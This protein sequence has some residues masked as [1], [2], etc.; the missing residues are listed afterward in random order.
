MAKKIF[1]LQNKLSLFFA[2]IAI[3]LVVIFIALV[4][5]FGLTNSEAK[6]VNAHIS[7]ELD[8]IHDKI[9]SDC[10]SVTLDGINLAAS[11]SASSNGFLESREISAAEFLR[12]PDLIEPY[13]ESQIYFLTA[14]INSRAC[15]GTFIILDTT[16]NPD[17]PDSKNSKAGLFLVKTQPLFTKMLGVWVHI[18]RGPA[19]IARK[20]GINLR[21]EWRLEYD[22]SENDTFDAIIESSRK[23]SHLPFSRLYYWTHRL[24]LK[25]YPESEFLL[26]VPIITKDGTVLG[27]CGIAISDIMFKQL[28][29]PTTEEFTG[30]FSVTAPIK[31]NKFL[32][33][34]GFMAGNYYVSGHFL[35]EN[36]D[37]AEKSEA[38]DFTKFNGVSG[39]YGGKYLPLRLYSEGSP[40]ENEKWAVAVMLPEK[41][42]DAAIS[43]NSKNFYLALAIILIVAIA[44]SVML[45]RYYMK[46]VH[47]AFDSIKHN[48]FDEDSGYLEISDLFEFLAEKD[49]EHEKELVD[50][51]KK[52]EDAKANFEDAQS[53]LEK[54]VDRQKYEVDAESYQ[55]FMENIG[56]LT[57]KERQIFDMYIS[58]FSAKDIVETSGITENTLKFHNKN[59]YGKL[60]IS[61]R[62]EMLMFAEIMNAK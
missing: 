2:S 13:L 59:I 24:V 16:A 23:N 33:S 35:G 45:S 7:T 56:T 48:S 62:K 26:I 40:Y 60:G 20:N 61:S 34:E 21:G 32:A 30:L 22:F 12:R 47:K 58:G 15:G 41:T 4:S 42:L 46:P 5:F 31:E 54:F 14:L 57:K 38:N 39:S 9:Y 49:K 55:M 29:S 3:F 50:L 10:T 19:D 52:T 36:L 37:I 51:E 17:L 43:G 53:R 44:A 28:Y 1:S 25:N 27:V 8:Y 18:L 11:I 6:R